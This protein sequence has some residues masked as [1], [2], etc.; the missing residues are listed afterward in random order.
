MNTCKVCN[1]EYEAKRATSQYCSSQCRVKASRL[2]VTES[3]EVSVTEVSV[4][5][6]GE[7]SV[8]DPHYVNR[9]NPEA[10]NW[11]DP[12]TVDE[13]KQAGFKANRVSIPG[14]HDYAGVCEEVEG[15]WQACT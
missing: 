1:E 6:P 8:T 2:S 10:L 3:G 9:T 14:D 7:F 11:G 15:K 5:G 13:L 12:M 4:T